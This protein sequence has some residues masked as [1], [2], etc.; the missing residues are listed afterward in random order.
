MESHLL[1]PSSN[2]QVEWTYKG[3]RIGNSWRLCL[4]IISRLGSTNWKSS[5]S[6]G[7][8]VM[9]LM[10]SSLI[11][12]E[13]ELPLVFPNKGWGPLVQRQAYS[14]HCSTIFEEK[15]P[16]LCICTERFGVNDRVIHECMLVQKMFGSI[17][18]IHWFK[19]IAYLDWSQFCVG[20]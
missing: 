14:N 19:G 3:G 12:V 5:R 2:V 11:K 15:G 16:K 6:F 9:L 1:I 7:G 8:L 10:S 18:R 4:W 17:Q 20:H 13:K